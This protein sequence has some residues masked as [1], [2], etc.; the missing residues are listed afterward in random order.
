MRASRLLVAI[1]LALTGWWY[2]VLPVSAATF[3][4]VEGPVLTND[5]R[6]FRPVSVNAIASPGQRVLVNSGGTARILYENGCTLVLDKPG[7][8]SV[9]ADTACATG[10]NTF[11]AAE[12]AIGAAVVTGIGLGIYQATRPASP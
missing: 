5:G 4:T 7:I 11:S 9:P 1:N 3:S 8:Y 6:G 10:I 12:V 2:L